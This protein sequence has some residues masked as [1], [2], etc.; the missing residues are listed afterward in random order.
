MNRLSYSVVA[1]MSIP[2]WDEAEAVAKALAKES[3]E[4]EQKLMATMQSLI[5]DIS[6]VEDGLEADR[7]AWEITKK[8][9]FRTI[10]AARE[11]EIQKCKCEKGIPAMEINAEAV[12]IKEE[13]EMIARL[14]NENALIQAEL[15]KLDDED[16]VVA[17]ER[18]QSMR[19]FYMQERICDHRFNRAVNG[20]LG[21]AAVKQALLKR[22][23][24]PNLADL[25]KKEACEEPEEED[26][27]LRFLREK[28]EAKERELLDEMTLQENFIR[29][30]HLSDTRALER[31]MVKQLEE[32]KAKE[33]EREEKRR[34]EEE[35]RMKKERLKELEAM[36]KRWKEAQKKSKK[37]EEQRQKEEEKR[38]REEEKRKREEERAQRRAQSGPS[39]WRRFITFISEQIDILVSE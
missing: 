20:F 33:L 15:D 32:I 10:E 34:R 29:A 7:K 18:E 17:K 2:E 19:D 25:L 27:R 30:F 11:D 37:E 22:V 38:K 28:F 1:A 8:E 39:I 5:Q 31:K 14:K 26:P 4:K 12:M 21:S 36:E 23:T 35:K 13:E 3:D 24:S 6:K 9:L 16:H